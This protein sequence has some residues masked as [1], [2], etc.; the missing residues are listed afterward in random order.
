MKSGI[1]MDII[2]TEWIDLC[3]NLQ[4]TPEETLLFCCFFLTCGHHEMQEL[5]LVAKSFVQLWERKKS[6]LSLKLLIATSNLETTNLE[7]W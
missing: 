1:L 3:Q 2:Q 4:E 5:H 6:L 7:H